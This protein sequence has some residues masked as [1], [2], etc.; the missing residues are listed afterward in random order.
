MTGYNEQVDKERVS[1][2]VKRLIKE[3]ENTKGYLGVEYDNL[4]I[5][6]DCT[7]LTESLFHSIMIE[8]NVLDG[9]SDESI[10]R[11]GEEHLP[12]KTQRN[13]TQH[14]VRL[15]KF[16]NKYAHKYLPKDDADAFVNEVKSYVKI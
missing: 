2:L 15:G 3:C 10:Q 8:L 13:V 14:M 12:F 11:E 7:S 9:N 1:F 16:V 4:E 6:D 5:D